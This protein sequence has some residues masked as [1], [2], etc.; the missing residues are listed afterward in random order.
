MRSA[1]VAQVASAGRIALGP[2]G[3]VGMLHGGDQHH[4]G[5]GGGGGGGGRG[6]DVA[7]GSCAPMKREAGTSSPCARWWR[8]RRPTTSPARPRGGHRRPR[9]CSCALLAFVGLSERII[10]SC[11]T[12]AEKTLD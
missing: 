1:H 11:L 8:G 7:G 3:Y 9:T 12:L 4:E 5:G 10:S 2:R 6:V